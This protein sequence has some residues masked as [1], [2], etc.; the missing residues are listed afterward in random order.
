MKTKTASAAAAVV[1][2]ANAVDARR[3][4]THKSK[5]G[6]Q[7][8]QGKSSSLCVQDPEDHRY[9][10]TCVE[11]E[12]NSIKCGDGEK[13]NAKGTKK[14]SKGKGKALYYD[15]KGNCVE[16]GKLKITECDPQFETNSTEAFCKQFESNTAGCQTSEMCDFRH[17]V[18]GCPFPD[19]ENG[20]SGCGSC[21]YSQKTRRNLN[22]W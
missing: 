18:G 19:G 17:H 16:A 15:G 14:S 22:E 2:A 5:S 6:K 10:A 7:G 8:K 4:L 13:I 3:D 1:A 11:R 12:D 21:T 20:D 9:G